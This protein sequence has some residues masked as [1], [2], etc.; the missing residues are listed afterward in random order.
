MSGT[1]RDRLSLGAAIASAP[2]ILVS[3]GVLVMVALLVVALGAARG[4]RTHAGF[5]PSLPAATA[6][7]VPASAGAPVLPG[8]SPRSTVLPS[9][10][11]ASPSVT[12][13]AAG[14]SA[15]PGP[16]APLPPASPMTGRFAVVTRFDTGFVGEV[17][18][19]NAGT[20][21]QGWTVRLT[22]PGGQ[23][24]DTW[25]AEAEQG[26]A[27]VSGGDLTYRSGVDLAPGASARL[28]F[29]IEPAAGTSPDVCTVNGARCAGF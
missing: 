2:C 17:L 29:R 20:T 26:R 3:I 9:P 25:V 15:R 8:L 16:P 4:R 14:G 6:S 18:I 12:S 10:P 11:V 1:R 5:P 19:V 13:G 28:R 21:A 23:V 22:F 7:R 24:A 27:T